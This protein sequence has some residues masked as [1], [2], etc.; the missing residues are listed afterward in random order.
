MDKGELAEQ[1]RELKSHYLNDQFMRETLAQLQKDL[2]SSGLG[3]QEE[4][5]PDPDQTLNAL[6]EL[7]R[8][9][10]E[11]NTERLFALLYRIDLS[12]R[13]VSAFL[14]PDQEE[15][16]ARAIAQAIMD[17]ELKKVIIRNYLAERGG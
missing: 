12:E 6:E 7:V 5:T 14:H 10:L 9:L 2:Q 3:F 1:L 16:P 15:E 8:T 17:R 4:L 11:E 13:E